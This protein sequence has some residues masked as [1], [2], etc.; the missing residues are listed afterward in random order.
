MGRQ[1]L[2]GANSFNL[3]ATGLQDAHVVD[4]WACEVQHFG[5]EKLVPPLIY[6]LADALGKPVFATG[7]GEDWVR[8]HETHCTTRVRRW[9]AEAYAFGHYFMYASRKW[10]FTPATGT[11]WSDVAPE[12]Y[13]PLAQ[14]LHRFPLL[15]DGYEPLTTVG[16]IYSNADMMRGDWEVRAAAGDRTGAWE[17]RDMSQSLLDACVSF[18]ILAAGNEWLKQRLGPDQARGLSRVIYPDTLTLDSEQR[19]VLDEWEKQDLAVPWSRARNQ[20]DLLPGRVT[21]NVPGKVWCLPRQAGAGRP[22]VVHLLN[23]DYQES[24]DAMVMQKQL[25][26]RIDVRLWPGLRNT[27]AVM[28]YTPEAE[29]KPLSFVVEQD[30]LRVRVPVLNLWGVM[31]IR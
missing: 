20:L 18:R 3:Q 9:I 17:A 13:L 26:V 5:V 4:Y 31:T 25:E 19:A 23:Q 6:K 8:F 2:V 12:V 27:R 15:F 29:P 10:G 7:G 1:V 22:L 11:V 16:L 30:S 21:T 14:F 24:G 28:L